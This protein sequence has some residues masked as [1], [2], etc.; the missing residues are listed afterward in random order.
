M[1][2]GLLV[3][4]PYLYIPV[5]DISFLVRY[6]QAKKF[7]TLVRSLSRCKKIIIKL[8]MVKDYNTCKLKLIRH[9]LGTTQ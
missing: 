8:N 5:L 9:G 7:A 6:N 1:V 4:Y 3:E 2:C